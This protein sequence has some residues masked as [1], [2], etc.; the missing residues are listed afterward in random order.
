MGAFLRCYPVQEPEV[1]CL[2]PNPSARG[3]NVRFEVLQHTDPQP[4]ANN[5]TGSMG[6][7]SLTCGNLLP[8]M[9]CA[10]CAL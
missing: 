4:L 7:I 10:R 3:A 5:A 6:N 8:Q 2:V 1:R 9:C